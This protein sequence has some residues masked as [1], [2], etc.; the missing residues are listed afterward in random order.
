MQAAQICFKAANC[1]KRRHPSSHE[2]AWASCLVEDGLHLQVKESRAELAEAREAA[3]EDAAKISTLAAQNK[4]LE[5]K[6]TALQAEVLMPILLTAWRVAQKMILYS[7]IR[8]SQI[9]DCAII[10]R[11]I[12]ASPWTLQFTTKERY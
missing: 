2:G 1:G 8:K 10:Q 7:K 6:L 11:A 3:T 5:S 4:L 12:T 9:F